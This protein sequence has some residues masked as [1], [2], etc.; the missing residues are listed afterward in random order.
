MEQS[1][2]VL[3]VYVVNSPSW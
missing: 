3:I 1:T 2:K